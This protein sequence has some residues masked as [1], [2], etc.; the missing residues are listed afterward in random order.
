MSIVW[1]LNALI[2]G[3]VVA[4]LIS[5]AATMLLQAAP[6]IRT[7][8]ESIM[9]LAREFFLKSLDALA[10]SP[11]PAADLESLIERLQGVRHISISLIRPETPDK[12]ASIP[13]EAPGGFKDEAAHPDASDDEPLRLPVLIGGKNLGMILIRPRPEDEIA[14]IW[15]AAFGVAQTGILL[16]AAAFLYIGWATRRSL[17]PIGELESALKQMQDG[18]Y[19]VGVN[20]EGPSEISGIARHVNNLAT[21][22][23]RARGE[24]SNLAEKLVTAQ[25]MERRDIARELHDELGPYLFSARAAGTALKSE[26]EKSEPNTAKMVRLAAT[27]LEHVEALQTTNRRVLRRLT[28]PGLSEVGLLASIEGLIAFWRKERPEVTIRLTASAEAGELD[29]TMTLTIY[30][31]IQEGLTNAMKH[32]HPSEVVI[33]IAL[34]AEP[35]SSGPRRTLT[36]A[37]EDDGEGLPEPIKP[38]LGLTGMRERVAALGGALLL[39]RPPNGGTRLSMT[40]RNRLIVTPITVSSPSTQRAASA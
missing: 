23:Q 15:E 36:L 10:H 5:F 8:N 17:R 16:S 38:G 33:E 21:A 22:L 1:R 12:A 28:P 37:I 6:R 13:S 26:A 18:D 7:E 29:E 19:D 14:E 27:M 25:D 24:N 2:A 32:A 3:L 34:T 4:L 31:V 35:G 20:P 30:R 11:Q 9:R 39:E 40:L